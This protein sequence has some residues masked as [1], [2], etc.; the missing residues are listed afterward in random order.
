MIKIITDSGSDILQEECDKVRV[1]PLHVSFGEEHYRDG[2]DLLHETFYEKLIETDVLPKTSQISPYEFMEAYRQELDADASAGEGQMSDKQILVI[3]LS[4][5]LSGTY[6]SACIAAE[7]FEGQVY[8]VDSEN[9]TVGQKCLVMRAV[10]LVEAD[11]GIDEIVGIL[12]EEKKQIQLIALLDTLEYLKK[13]G[14]I[15]AASAA[16]G[17]ALSIKPVVGVGAGEILVLGKAHGSKNG[18]N[19]LMQR[20][21]QAGGIDFSRPFYLGYT[22]LSDKLICKYIEDS[23]MLWEKAHTKE[24]LPIVS[25]GAAIGTHVGPGA[26]AVAFFAPQ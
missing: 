17:N 5:R 11:Y 4:S 10:E 6:Q 25:V 20:T 14:R 1:L 15:S 2:V 24:E 7:E 13:G 23:R 26:I 18:K 22:G 19:L 9:V 16:L 3:T 12:E 8:V 21:K